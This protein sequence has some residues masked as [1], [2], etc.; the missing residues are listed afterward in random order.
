MFPTYRFVFRKETDRLEQPWYPDGAVHRGEYALD[1]VDP[2]N[3]KQSQRITMEPGDPCTLGVSQ[4]GV[5]VERDQPLKLSLFL[6]AGQRH[7]ARARHDLGRRQDV[8]RSGVSAGPAM[9]AISGHPD[10]HDTDTHATVTISFRGPGTLWI[11]QVSLLPQD[12]V[13]GWRR[14]V[15]EATQGAQAGHHSLRRQHDRGIRL[16]RHDR[17][18]D[19]A[20]PV[21]D[22]LG[23]AGAGQCR[24]G[25]VRSALPMGRR[26]AADLHPLHRQDAAGRRGSSRVLQRPGR[27]ADGPPARGRTA[28]P[29]P[30]ACSTGRSATNWATKVTSRAW[31]PSARP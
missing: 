29:N 24:P 14:D 6:K 22:V 25:G 13:F 9:A 15:A 12:T 23:R 20:R 21:H 26:R 4:A 8:C 17:R 30:T 2:F 28:T 11:D 1:T 3:G 18:P 7:R 19:A 31:P 16:D 27:H 5:Y 10:S